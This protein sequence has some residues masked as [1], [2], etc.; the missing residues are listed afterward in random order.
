MV[1][2]TDPNGDVKLKENFSKLF[3]WL[4]QNHTEVGL[5]KAELEKA[6]LEKADRE[7]AIATLVQAF[8]MDGGEKKE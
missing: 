6:N 2:K 3:K 8:A 1:N 5:E 7:K 4:A